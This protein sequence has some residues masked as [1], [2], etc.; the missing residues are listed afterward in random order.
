MAQLQPQA[1]GG[2]RLTL[3]T[4]SPAPTPAVAAPPTGPPSLAD[5]IASAPRARYWVLAAAAAGADGIL[6]TGNLADT[7][8]ALKTAREQGITA[9]IADVTLKYKDMVALTNATARDSV[10]LSARPR[11]ETPEQQLVRL[12]IRGFT[13]AEELIEAAQRL[14]RGEPGTALAVDV[15]G[16]T[17]PVTGLTRTDSTPGRS[18]RCSRTASKYSSSLRRSWI[19]K[20]RRPRTWCTI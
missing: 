16:K 9:P 14:E 18:S 1:G 12:N 15:R 5:L 4:P 19:R 10:S 11:A 8:M 6:I 2:Y 7:V 17:L 20:R 3:E 13:I